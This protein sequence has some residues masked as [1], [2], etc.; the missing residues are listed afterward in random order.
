MKRGVAIFFI[1]FLISITLI[2][3]VNAFSLQDI[4][5]FFNNVFNIVGKAIYSP[6][7]MPVQLECYL[8]SSIYYTCPDGFQFKE[9]Y[10]KEPECKPICKEITKSEDVPSILNIKGSKSKTIAAW[11]DSCTGELIKEAPY[12]SC[13]DHEAKCS[14]IGT[15]NEGWYDTIT[16]RITETVQTMGL[17]KHDQCAP[18]WTCVENPQDYCIGHG[19]C[20]NDYDC[21]PE[22]RCQENRCIHKQISK[23]KIKGRVQ[24]YHD[25]RNG[26]KTYLKSDD[27][28]IL[29]VICKDK[30]YPNSYIEAEGYFLDN[31]FTISSYNLLSPIEIE[32]ENNLGEQRTIAILIKRAWNPEPFDR[33]FINSVLN[34]LN[35]FVIENTFN[36]T[37]LSIDITPWIN[38][39]FNETI[40]YLE[41]IEIADP[42]VNFSNYNTIMIFADSVVPYS[43]VG[44]ITIETEEGNITARVMGFPVEGI[45]NFTYYSEIA[46]LSHELGHGF[47]FGHADGLICVGG[48]FWLVGANNC[49]FSIPYGDPFDAMGEAFNSEFASPHYGAFFKKEAG[50]SSPLYYDFIPVGIIELNISENGLLNNSLIFPYS[51]NEDYYVF[52]YRYPT[53]FDAI[54]DPSWPSIVP[55]IYVHYA[56]KLYFDYYHTGIIDTHPETPNVF[57]AMLLPGETYIDYVKGFSVTVLKLSPSKAILFFKRL[58]ACFEAGGVCRISCLE[59]ESEN[60]NLSKYCNI[61]I[62]PVETT[63]AATSEITQSQTQPQSQPLKKC[64]FIKSSS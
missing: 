55:G 36:Q 13:E 54:Y 45:Y 31:Y 20:Y 15:R 1:S 21:N 16:A 26:Y 49:Q 29:N 47:G 41:A 57:D 6:P 2:T 56:N 61:Q 9:C 64:C 14:A 28:K 58:N 23:L 40:F 50:W 35:D 4:S 24:I 5:N 27:G 53:G 52:E 33:A 11:Y 62:S 34:K 43:F 37:W 32:K 10:C 8:R 22:E 39:S 3:S 17:I 18:K 60:F 51:N 46:I 12:N 25:E 7:V 30:L 38:T 59:N 48:P 42:F 19:F 63:Q 44:P